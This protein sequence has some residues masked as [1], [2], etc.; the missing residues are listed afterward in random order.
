MGG[1]HFNDSK[2]GL[3]ALKGIISKNFETYHSEININLLE[4]DYLIIPIFLGE[5]QK[6]MIVQ[7]CNK[8]GKNNPKFNVILCNLSEEKGK[9]YVLAIR[10]I[11]EMAV[12]KAKINKNVNFSTIPIIVEI[13][14]FRCQ[15][16][17]TRKTPVFT[18]C[19][20]W[21]SSSP[22][23]AQNCMTWRAIQ[24]GWS[25]ISFQDAF[26]WN[27]ARKSTT[28]SSSW[29][30]SNLSWSVFFCAK[31]S[32]AIAWRFAMRLRWSSTTTISTSARSRSTSFSSAR[33]SQRQTRLQPSKTTWST[34]W[35][36]RSTT[37]NP[38]SDFPIFFIHISYKIKRIR[39]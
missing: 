28:F 8:T 16:N 20:V 10:T 4:P 14:L 33:P 23:N 27:P 2:E 3:E 37:N 6:C 34:I 13:A 29:Q 17:R 7:L 15:G 18:F 31:S 30:R 1:D 35:T 19:S 22:R 36:T 26:P 24:A 38:S 32:S 39:P 11:L 21:S 9:M 25:C 5:C 12:V